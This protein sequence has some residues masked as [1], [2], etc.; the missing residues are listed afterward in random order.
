MQRCQRWRR[1]LL[2]PARTC[3][4]RERFTDKAVGIE[5]SAGSMRFGESDRNI[6]KAFTGNTPGLGGEGCGIDWRG[7][8]RRC[9]SNALLLFLEAAGVTPPMSL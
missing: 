6:A 7:P 4:Q 8:R 9:E 2:S 1:E 3:P 5:A